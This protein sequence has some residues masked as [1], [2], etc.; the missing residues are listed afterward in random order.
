MQ[1]DRLSTPVLFIIFNRLDTTQRVFEAIRQ[2][3]PSR[4]YIAADGPRNDK[5]GENLKVQAVRDYVLSHIDWQCEVKT[6]FWD[7]NRG[8][9]VAVSSA[10]DWF[11]LNEEEGIILEDDCFPDK[12]FFPFCAELLEKYRQDD[13]VMM[14]SGDNFQ[15]GVSRSRSYYFSRYCHIWGWASWRRAWKHYDVTIPFWPQICK[16]GF[17]NTLDRRERLYWKWCFGQVFSGRLDTWDYQWVLACWIKK[18]LAAVPAVNLV[19]NIGIG[20][21]S[22]HTKE[23]DR[24]VLALETERMVFP[25]IHPDEIVADLPLDK[26]TR[27]ISYRMSVFEYAWRKLK[28]IVRI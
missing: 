13:R 1:S 27:D 9:K 23:G 3:L 2:V 17:L 15:S 20:Q 8:C 22:T 6:L 12:S 24:R 10:I 19:L 7:K 28:E 11:F 26:N 16:D 5:L 14:I 25:L 21:D 18:G 4:L